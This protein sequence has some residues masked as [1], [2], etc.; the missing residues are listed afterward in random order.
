VL[1]TE[2][3]ALAALAALRATADDFILPTSPSSS[4]AAPSPRQA[5]SP[6]PE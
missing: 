3:A 6:D 4:V 2:T 5:M 1:R